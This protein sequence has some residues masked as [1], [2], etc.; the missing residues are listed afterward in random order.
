MRWKWIVTLGLAIPLGAAVGC[1]RHEDDHKHGSGHEDGGHASHGGTVAIPDHYKD[2]VLKCEELST[3]IGQLIQAGNLRDIPG[4]AGDV[5]KIAEKL[6]ELAQKVVKADMLKEVNIKSKDLTAI[7][8][9]MDEAE[10][11]GNKE[12]MQ[13]AHEKM[14]GLIAELKKHTEAGH[15]HH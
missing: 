7:F 11:A 5:K 3:K 9:E 14:K 6:P 12:A 2:A 10:H 15:E 4:A 1:D 13:K 8:E